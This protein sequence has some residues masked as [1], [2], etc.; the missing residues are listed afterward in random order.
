LEKYQ[1]NNKLLEEIGNCKD[2]RWEW[3][4]THQKIL[5]EVNS[6]ESTTK[7]E[8]KM[9]IKGKWNNRNIALC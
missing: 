7:M 3:E 6:K 9:G 2:W 1:Q 5:F 8:P 4:M